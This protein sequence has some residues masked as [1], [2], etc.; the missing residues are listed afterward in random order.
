MPRAIALTLLLF[1]IAVILVFLTLRKL[2]VHPLSTAIGSFLMLFSITL[3]SYGYHL[4]STVWNFSAG[5]FFLWFAVSQYS[6]LSKEVYLKRI[7]WLAGIL[8]FFSY[9]IVFYWAAFLFAYFIMHKKDADGETWLKKIFVF[10]KS[11]TSAILLI[12][13]CAFLFYPF[14]QTPTEEIASF[15]D[16]FYFPYYIILNIFSFY[17]KSGAIDIVQFL[18]AIALMTAGAYAIGKDLKEKD[19]ILV[20]SMMKFFFLIVIAPVVLDI[21]SLGPSR[22]ILFIAPFL[23]VLAGVGLDFIFN[24]FNLSRK[25]GVVMIILLIMIGFAF[26]RVRTNDTFD[27]TSLIKVDPS[28]SHVRIIG[29]SF[30]LLYKN[31]G[32]GRTVEMAK[33]D[34]TKGDTYYYVGEDPLNLL[35]QKGMTVDIIGTENVQTGIQFTAYSPEKYPWDRQNGFSAITFRVLK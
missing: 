33:S 20:G 13:L 26:L 15:R 35:P 8:V 14:G 21:L 4:G 3:Y 32:E 24:R 12:F 9:I 16:V 5:A 2:R 30:H 18:V 27:K 29:C 28:V 25:I 17:N 11:Q 10:L 7:S 6:K 23:F 1:H 31:W 19:R 22:H 34:Y